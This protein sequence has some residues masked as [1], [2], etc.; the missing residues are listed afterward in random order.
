MTR[1]R[2]VDFETTGIPSEGCPAGIIEIGACDVVLSQSAG[3]F[4][5]DESSAWSALCN[6]KIAIDPEAQ[7]VHHIDTADLLGA[8]SPDSH[9][10]RLCAGATHFAAHNAEFEREF[11]GGG[12]RPWI[13]TLK[14]AYR[15]YPDAPRHSNSVLRYWLKFPLDR[16]KADL[17]HRAGP[18]AY[19]TAHL[20]C[21]M[22]NSGKASVDDMIRWSKGAALLPRCPIGEW[23]GKPWAEVPTSFLQWA[24]KKDGMRKDVRANAKHELKKRGV[25]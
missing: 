13:C 11:F 3:G 25:A 22:L 15:V 24:M 23:S 12:E 14:V 20:L 10:V 21:G 18:D 1:I 8:P 17:A 7:A 9:F 19:V 5:V 2:V 4:Y 16:A 6:P